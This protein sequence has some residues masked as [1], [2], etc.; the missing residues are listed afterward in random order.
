MMKKILCL[1]LAALA[2]LSLAACNKELNPDVGTTAPK[3]LRQEDVDAAMQKL[4]VTG[5]VNNLSDEQRKKL[6][7]ALRKE[8][9]D[10][11][12]A[13]KDLQVN[14]PT[15]LQTPP[16][17]ASV[18]QPP[19]LPAGTEVSKDA[20]RPYMQKMQEIINSKN[21]TMKM[22]S[23]IGNPLGE[24]GS[25]MPVVMVLQD[26]NS[27]TEMTIDWTSLTKSMDLKYGQQALMA[28]TLYTAMG[29]RM[30][31][32]IADGTTYLAFP[33]R[34]TYISMQELEQANPDD[35]T[36]FDSSMLGDLSG[37]LA[38]I[39]DDTK[40][41]KVTSGG[42]NY[43]CAVVEG[44]NGTYQKY[45]FLAD[46]ANAGTLKRI[47]VKGEDGSLLVN[48]IEEFRAGAD[49]S[50]FSVKGMAKMSPGDFQN[51]LKGFEGM[52]S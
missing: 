27:A 4:G 16:T 22:R 21:F 34:K 47:E 39:P 46:G 41:T 2:L 35:Q 18:T 3:F 13:N 42:V 17:E 1:A 38:V 37:V 50:Y 20:A 49:T 24:S 15:N 12:V 26:Q 52:M 36:A 23:A 40:S 28:A 10:V 9:F 45:Y 6:Q 33:D 48:E 30:R 29:K 51:L 31:M 14:I 5:D 25:Y 43:L 8:G 19:A 7:D 11:A 32:V 44:E